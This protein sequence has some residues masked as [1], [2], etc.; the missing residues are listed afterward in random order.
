MMSKQNN[1]SLQ[2][3]PEGQMADPT[4]QQMDQLNT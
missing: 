4:N 1:S 3:F 2:I